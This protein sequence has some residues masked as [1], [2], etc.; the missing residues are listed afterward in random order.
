M[1][2]TMPRLLPLLL[3]CLV[4]LVPFASAGTGAKD[5]YRSTKP[6]E[7][8]YTAQQV[9]K[10]LKLQANPE[11]GYF[12]ETFRDTYLVGSNGTDRSAG[13]AIYYL[14]EGRVG[15]SL[16]HRLD[17][18]EVWHYYA[19]APMKL[20]LSHN[21]GT[22]VRKLVMGPDVFDHQ[23]PQVVIASWEWQ[24]VRSYGEW[25]LVGTTVSPGFDPT[26]YE[27]ED[28]GWNPT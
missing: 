6:I 23:S 27:I 17:A 19:G 24:R 16:W 3:S 8:R 22:G 7:K 2:P 11:K 26:Q 15:D 13:T 20:E 10:Q 14:I 5:H 28:E 21:N 1:A 18:A 12:A 4:C 25:T 9:I